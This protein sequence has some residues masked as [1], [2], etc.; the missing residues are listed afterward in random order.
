MSP[1]VGRIWLRQRCSKLAGT[2]RLTSMPLGQTEVPLRPSV[3]RLCMLLK[4]KERPLC[5]QHGH[6]VQLLDGLGKSLGS[7]CRPPGADM[8]ENAF[9]QNVLGATCL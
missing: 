7:E 9:V 4:Q 1:L 6:S 2:S 5:K 3:V 8:M